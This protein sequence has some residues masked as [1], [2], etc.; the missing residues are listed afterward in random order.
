[1]MLHCPFVFQLGHCLPPAMFCHHWLIQTYL[2][3]P[4]LSFTGPA[5][6][7]G[8]GGPWPIQLY[9][10]LSL[11][12]LLTTGCAYQAARPTHRVVPRNNFIA[13]TSMRVLEEWFR[14]RG[15]LLQTTSRNPMLPWLGRGVT[16]GGKE[17]FP[18][19]PRFCLS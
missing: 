11:Q 7:G 8:P 5:H 18:P 19:W 1:M 17:A 3:N 14:S 9:S 12:A 4:V 6:K 15:L 13:S 2:V 10:C 16:H